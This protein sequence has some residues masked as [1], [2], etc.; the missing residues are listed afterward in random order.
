MF[1][2][3][4]HPDLAPRTT[5]GTALDIYVCVQEEREIELN[6]FFVTGVL[7][8]SD[9]RECA[10]DDS[11]PSTLRESVVLHTLEGDS[12]LSTVNV[13]YESEAG[14]A[15]SCDVTSLGQVTFPTDSAAVPDNTTQVFATD[16]LATQTFASNTL[17]TRSLV[18]P[19]DNPVLVGS[20]EGHS[21]QRG[22]VAHSS[23]LSLVSAGT[24]SH[25]GSEASLG[26]KE[27]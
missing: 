2:R 15:T 8:F 18:F 19:P 9:V 25:S 27:P 11:E 24:M 14:S 26:V 13:L 5:P 10:A 4:P 22:G 21:L 12:E 1:G 20:E 3:A 6:E 16:T 17:A 23:M 7:R